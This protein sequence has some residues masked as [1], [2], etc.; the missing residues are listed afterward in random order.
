MGACSVTR[1]TKISSQVVLAI[2]ATGL[3]SFCGV[4]VETA[5]NISFPTLM[6]EFHVHTSTVQWLTTLY[7]LVVASIVPLSAT[8]KKR[9]RTKHLFVVANMLFILGLVLDATATHFWVLLL[10]RGIQGIGTGIALP[11]M[12]NII[13]EQVPMSRIGMMM[14]VGT[15]IT[16]IAP[17][18]GPTFGGLVISKLNWRAIFLILLPLLIVSLILGFL[19]IQQI[20]PLQHFK[21]DILSTLLIIVTFV[22]LVFGLSSSS[23]QVLLSWQVGGALIL[24]VLALILFV[25]RSQRQVTPILDLSVFQNKSFSAHVVALALLQIIALALSFILPNY[26]QLVHRDNALVAGLI[27]FPGALIGAILSPLSGTILDHFGAKKPLISGGLCSLLAMIL[28]CIVGRSMTNGFVGG[29]YAVFT[30]GIGI[31]YGNIMTNGL[32]QLS[33]A[34]KA[35]GNAMFTTA[36][37]F[38]GAVGTA[39]AS[40]S[41]ALG[42]AKRPVQTTGT[43]LGAWYAFIMLSLLAFLAVVSIGLALRWSKNIT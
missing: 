38:F 1:P 11:L 14:G 28:Y 27:V 24:G 2:V 17:A 21:F 15:L 30:I 43:A 18:I 3:L 10:G 13:L 12:F 16:A 31:C 41:V 8:L 19:T 39:L 7:L 20:Q 40:T 22:G 29:I 5:M 36:Q 6:A 25:K 34:Q 32:K 35:D 37:Q 4:I 26:I 23:Q 33:V 9:F 42:Q